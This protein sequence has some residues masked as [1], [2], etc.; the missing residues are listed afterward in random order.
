MNISEGLS[1]VE[2]LKPGKT[3]FTH[4]THRLDHETTNAALPEGVELAYDGLRWMWFEIER[5][6]RCWKAWTQN[7]SAM[8]CLSAPD[9]W[10]PT[11]PTFA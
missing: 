8:E 10:E 7:H 9:R 1:V 6:H 5:K 11:M 2:R 4:I 3:F